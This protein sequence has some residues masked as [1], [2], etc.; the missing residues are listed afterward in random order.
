MLHFD[1]CSFIIQ[2][3]TFFLSL[4][5]TPFKFVNWMFL[6]TDHDSKHD[7]VTIKSKLTIHLFY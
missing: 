3:G 5:S 1:F 7:K 2:F 4:L 6:L